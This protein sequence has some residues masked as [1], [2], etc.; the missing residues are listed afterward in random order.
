MLYVASQLPMVASL[1][2][3]P[4]NWL[5]IPYCILLDIR[6]IRNHNFVNK[7]VPNYVSGIHIR[8]GECESF[9]GV[10]EH[11]RALNYMLYFVLG[12]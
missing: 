5:T 10:F 12:M 8:Y 7:R 3:S 4:D 1:H 9:P 2:I 6:L 11:D